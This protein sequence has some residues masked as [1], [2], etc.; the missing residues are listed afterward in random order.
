[1]PG[2]RSVD[3]AALEADLGTALPSDFRSLAEAYPILVID[4]FLTVSVP[5][6]GAE[7]SW[8][9]ESREDEI[10]QDLYEMGDTEGYVPFP[11][12]GGLI[13]WAET[14]SGDFFYWRT[15]PAAPDAWPVVVRTDN[16]DWSEFPVGAVEFLAGV[17]RRTL[18]VSGM[19]RN[20]PGDDPK[21][22]GL[23]D[24]ID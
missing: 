14:N 17:Y 1:M 19:P 18:D 10:L 22:L 21:V 4:D 2:G 9:S 16:G 6:P 20:F 11:R 8:A 12:P 23:S 24:R 13:C 3:W 7:A 15:S 5:R